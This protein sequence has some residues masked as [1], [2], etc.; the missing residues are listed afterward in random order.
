MDFE[1]YKAS[2]EE[3]LRKAELELSRAEGKVLKFKRIVANPDLS[4]REY[5]RSRKKQGKS[6]E[7]TPS[8]PVKTQ[9]KKEKSPP[10]SHEKPKETP[11]ESE[12]TCLFDD[13]VSAFKKPL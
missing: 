1:K 2:N 13:L 10:L 5:L 7:I 3:R 9:D 8:F 6:C 11:P 12:G 4:Y